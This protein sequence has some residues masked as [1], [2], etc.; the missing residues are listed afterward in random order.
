MAGMSAGS[1]MMCAITM[2][3]VRS[4]IRASIC[5]GPIL[6]EPGIVST[7]IGMQLFMTIGMTPPLSV[8]QP[9]KTSENGGRSNA[10]N[11]TKTEFV[12]EFTPSA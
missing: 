1:P 4:V 8:M 12:P 10:R 2:A 6:N 3:D 11:A 7:G 5:S 9:N